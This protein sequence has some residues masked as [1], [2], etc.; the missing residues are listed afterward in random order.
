MSAVYSPVTLAPYTPSTWELRL[1]D[2]PVLAG[3]WRSTSFPDALG[4]IPNGAE[5]RLIYEN[6][7]SAEALALIKPW[8]ATG[9]G[10]WALSELPAELAFGVDNAAFRRRLTKTTWTIARKPQKESVKNGR[11]NVTIDLIYE[12]TFT[13][14][15]GPVNPPEENLDTSLAGFNFI[16]VKATVTPLRQSR[17]PVSGASGSFVT[18]AFAGIGAGVT[19]SPQLQKTIS[20]PSISMAAFTFDEIEA[21]N[22]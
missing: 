16:G 7:T 18:L 14:R 13:S 17:I 11:F 9:G 4:S 1:P 8:R 5:W 15:Y 19:P 20:G 21:S 6:C 22:L 2:Y 12:L 3:A 10:Q